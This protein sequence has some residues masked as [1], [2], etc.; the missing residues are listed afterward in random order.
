MF[1]WFSSI[2][3]CYFTMFNA[4]ELP[5]DEMTNLMLFGVSEVAGVFL[6]ERFITKVSDSTGMILC[7]QVVVFANLIIK[8]FTLPTYVTYVLF[9]IQVLG[10]GGIYSLI[11]IINEKKVDPKL[12]SISLELNYSLATIPTIFVPM[13][14]KM[15]EPL[16]TIAFSLFCLLGLVM[17][18]IMPKDSKQQNPQI[19]I[20][21]H[22]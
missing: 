17:T 6:I 8:I 5:G 14:A 4:V 7:L 1:M 15:E 12:K 3:I 21:P 20:I 18:F 13:L 16:P 9:V 11:I 2:N 10:T 19:V 22:E